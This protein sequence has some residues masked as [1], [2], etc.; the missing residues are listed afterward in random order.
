[1][2]NINFQTP[3]QYAKFMVSLLNKRDVKTALDP[4]PGAGNLV[5]TIDDRFGYHYDPRW[6]YETPT[7]PF[8]IDAIVMNPPFTPM[9]LGYENLFRAMELTDNIIALMPWLTII[10]SER[11]TKRILDYGLK[12]IY[13]LPRR[14]FK[15]SRVQTCILYMERGF[16]S[17]SAGISFL[18]ED[19]LGEVGRFV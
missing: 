6:F 3:P 7:V 14:A 17:A 8:Q 9:K 15:G 5:A 2:D 1:M 11:R 4:H 19:Q 12:E 18:I 10:N 16:H 13:H